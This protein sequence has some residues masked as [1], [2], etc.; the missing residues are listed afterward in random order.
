MHKYIRGL[1]T[2]VEHIAITIMIHSWEGFVQ[3]V[4]ISSNFCMK[5]LMG[6]SVI[7]SKLLRI[8]SYFTFVMFL[9]L[10]SDISLT[11]NNGSYRFINGSNLYP[12]SVMGTFDMKKLTVD[13]LKSGVNMEQP[14]NIV[15]KARC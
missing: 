13:I 8:K 14:S 11:L 7:G 3:S 6:T 2:S 10:N 12:H 4:S 9:N 5:L 1:A 15:I